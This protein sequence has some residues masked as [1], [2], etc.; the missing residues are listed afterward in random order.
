MPWFGK[1]Y[2][3]KKLIG[4]MMAD[5]DLRREILQII[6]KYDTEIWKEINKALYK[7]RVRNK[8]DSSDLS[9]GTYETAIKQYLD[10]IALFGMHIILKCKADR[11]KV[12]G[13][14]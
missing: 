11:F 14:R 10:K 5:D 6:M 13:M 9:K 12:A 1:D 2:S 8:V 3:E 7:S 4:I